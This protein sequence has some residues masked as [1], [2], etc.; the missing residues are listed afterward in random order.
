[1][2]VVRGKEEVAFLH[3]DVCRSAKDLRVIAFAEFGKEDA[4]GLCP[5]AL[6]RACNEAGLVAELLRSR[7]YPFAGGGR[8][9]AAGCVV[10]DEG[11]GCRTEVQVFGEHLEADTARS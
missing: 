10:Q 3:E 4:D 7:L 5:K 2:T 11:D 6:E 1:V 9:R 8:D